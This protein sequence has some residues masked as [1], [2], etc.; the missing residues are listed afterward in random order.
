[1]REDLA[2]A[3]DHT[4]LKPEADLAAVQQLCAEALEHGFKTVCVNRVWVED[5]SRLLAGSPVGVCSVVGFPLGATSHT[6]KA[7]E[8]AEAVAAGAD[9][10]DMVLAIGALKQGSLDAVRTDIT[11]VVRAAEGKIV[12]VIIETCLL[13]DDEKVEACRLSAEAGAHF[14]KTSTGFGSGG[15][16]IEDVRLMRRTVGEALGVKASGGIRTTGHADAFI[17]AGASR[18]GTSSGIAIVTGG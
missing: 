18:L 6:V 7:F 4:L 8:T 17:E 3:I 2:A 5:A 1:V 12:K 10:I 16:T 15:A 11:S 9:E 14:V 13:A